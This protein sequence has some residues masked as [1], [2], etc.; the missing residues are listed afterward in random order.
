VTGANAADL[1]PD[2]VSVQGSVGQR[3][4]LMS[5]LAVAW[6]WEWELLRRR[7]AITGQTELFVNHWRAD[8]VD[9]GRDS[10]TQFGLLP[11][12][13]FHLAQGR[14]PWFIELG[15][16]AS[17]LDRSFQTPERRFSTRFNFYDVIGAGYLFGEH[18]QHELGLRLLHISNAGIK[19][20]NPGQDFVQLRYLSRF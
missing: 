16:G 15:I 1:R 20:P 19:E 14:S 4:T 8:A 12:L 9:G 10:Y 11:S 18:R 6:D 13:R 5:G 7:A 17:W 2:G 3:G